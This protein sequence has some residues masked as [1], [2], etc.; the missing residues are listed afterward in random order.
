MISHVN[1]G[2]GIDVSIKNVSKIIKEVVGFRGKVVFDNT[3]PDG[4]KRKL[5]DISKI[6]NLGW[7]PVINLKNG[8]GQTYNWFLEN[9]KELRK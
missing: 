4:P 6:E 1:V 3:M 8:L 2:T 5:L 9:S 7:K